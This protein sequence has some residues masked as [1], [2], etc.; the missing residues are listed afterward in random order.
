[1]R[2]YPS[3]VRITHMPTGEQAAVE[4]RGPYRAQWR[5]R[6]A[7]LAVL[8]ARLWALAHGGRSEREVCAVELP[9][10]QEYP[11]ELTAHRAPVGTLGRGGS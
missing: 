2:I 3:T 8:R 7:A 5:A 1:V 4:Q 11:P 10:G 6:D 9:E